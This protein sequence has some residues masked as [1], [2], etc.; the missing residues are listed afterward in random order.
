MWKLSTI[1]TPTGGVDLG[2]MQYK[3]PSGVSASS[4][5]LLHKQCWNYCPNPKPKGQLY[6]EANGVAVPINNDYFRWTYTVGFIVVAIIF[7]IQLY[8]VLFK[9]N[10]NR[11]NDQ[12]PA[13]EMKMHRSSL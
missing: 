10:K 12:K 7:L 11:G 8:S 3:F 5:T 6:F 1:N 13:T 2:K 9:Q 4:K